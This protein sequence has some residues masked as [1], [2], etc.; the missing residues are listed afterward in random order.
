MYRPIAYVKPLQLIISFIKPTVE[1][2]Y[3]L[4]S[5]NERRD[6]VLHSFKFYLGSTNHLSCVK[7]MA[8]EILNRRLETVNAKELKL[9]EKPIP[10]TPPQGLIVKV[11]IVLI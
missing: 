5:E 11:K 6:I 3:G 10:A 1:T 2:V 8:K 9:V 7:N 4:V